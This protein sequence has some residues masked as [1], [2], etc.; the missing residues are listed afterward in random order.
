[1]LNAVGLLLTAVK[2]ARAWTH[3]SVFMQHGTKTGVI[4][5]DTITHDT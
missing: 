5:N 2:Q 1:M 4:P 3:R